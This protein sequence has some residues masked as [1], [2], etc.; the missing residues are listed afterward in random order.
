MTQIAE[1]L[2]SQLAELDI[3]DRAEIA[4]FL[5]RTLDEEPEDPDAERLW[6]VELTRREQEILNR[7]EAGIPAEEVL[8]KLRARF[9]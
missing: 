4:H 8:E 6:E 5:I 1:Q 9:H 3:K 7:T 2:K